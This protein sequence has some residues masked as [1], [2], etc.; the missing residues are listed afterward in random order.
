LSAAQRAVLWALGWMERYRYIKFGIVGASGTVVNLLVLYLG[1]EYLFHHIEADYKR[2]YLSL[3]LAIFLATINNFT[4][5]RLWT[6]R[7]RVAALE[8]DVAYQP[9]GLR[10][11]SVEFG[12]YA[13][14]SAFGSAL[15]YVLTLLLSGSMDYRLANV[16]AIIAA[17]VSNFLANDRWT[18][19]RR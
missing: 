1:H 19:R 2:P 3:A 16:I 8:A 11:L 18:F 4:W 5:N 15:Q 7:D 17:S 9:V 14:A 13:T 10:V 12:Q 6:W